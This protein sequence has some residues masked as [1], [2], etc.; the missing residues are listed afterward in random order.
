MP[1]RLEVVCALRG[2]IFIGFIV[3]TLAISCAAGFAADVPAVGSL[4]KARSVYA[5]TPLVLGASVSGNNASFQ[6]QLNG[7]D[8]AA[9]TNFLLFV[10]RAAATNAGAYSL[11]VSN[12]SGVV[13]GFVATVSVNPFPDHTR[14]VAWGRNTYSQTNIAFFGEAIACSAG[15]GHSVLLQKD[16]S[17]LVW[18]KSQETVVPTGLTNAVAIS[19]GS[20]HTLAL[21][22]NGTVVAW[23]ENA[24]G[25]CD[26]PA[27]LHDVVAVSANGGAS[28]A[29]KTDGTITMWGGKS[30]PF[31]QT[32]V[33]V[34]LN[35]VVGISAGQ[36][37]STAVRGDGTIVAW[38]YNNTGQI[39]VPANIGPAV[40]ICAGGFHTV[41]TLADGTVTAWGAPEFGVT[42]PPP[43]LSSPVYVGA[44][45]Y[46]TL[47]IS[48]DGQLIAWGLGTS[49]DTNAPSD[50][51]GQSTI[52]PNL[53]AA[54]AA[55]AG[56]HHNVALV[57]DPVVLTRDPQPQLAKPGST[58][59]LSAEASSL[60]CSFAWRLNG[61]ALPDQT[62]QT[63]TLPNFSVTAQGDYDVVVT[64][65]GRSQT[66]RVARV[67]LFSPTKTWVGLGDNKNWYDPQN[68]SP[69][70]RPAA[71]DEVEIPAGVAD[72]PEISS[73]AAPFVVKNLRCE[74]AFHSGQIEVSG[75]GLF[76]GSYRS[77]GGV[78]IQ[79]TGPNGWLYFSGDT[80][81]NDATLLATG[82]GWIQMPKPTAFISGAGSGGS[83]TATGAGSLIETIGLLE[84][85]GPQEGGRFLRLVAIDGGK[86]DMPSL[87]T[88]HSDHGG[89]YGAPSG[90]I[91]SASGAGTVINLPALREFLS[92]GESSGSA[93]SRAAGADIFVP[94]LQRAQAVSIDVADGRAFSLPSLT[95]YVSGP[96]STCSLS[97]RG[98]GSILDLPS[99]SK[100]AGPTFVYYYLDIAAFEGGVV[101]LPK[102]SQMECSYVN[103]PGGNGSDGGIRVRSNGADSS[104]NLPS[105]SGF[106]GD[107]GG[108]KIGSELHST[109]GGQIKVPNLTSATGLNLL[110]D[111]NSTLLL[112]AL[113]TYHSGSGGEGAFS[114]DGPGAIVSAPAL[115][116]LTGPSFAY[117]FFRISARH[118]GL[119]SAPA[120]ESL[121]CQYVNPPGGN[122]GEGGIVVTC[123]DAGSIIDFRSLL[124]FTGTG[125]TKIGSSFT[126]ASGGEIRAP[127]L[128]NATGLHL[129]CVDG[130]V[131]NMA[132][133][134]NAVAPASN[135]VVFD[136]SGAG[137]VLIVTNLQRFTGP[138]LLIQEKGGIVVTNPATLYQQVNLQLAPA[139]TRNP[140]E[141]SVL[142]GTP[143]EIKLETSGSPPIFQW[144]LN[145]QGIPGSTN[146]THAIAFASYPDAGSYFCI[147]SNTFGSI[148]SA[149]VRVTVA[150]PLT[151]DVRGRGSV[152]RNPVAGSD[153]VGEP[154]TLQAVPADSFHAFAGWADGSAQNPRSI[155]IGVSN[156][157]L[158]LFTNKIPLTNI[159][160]KSWEREIGGENFDWLDSV[161]ST[162]DGGFI[163]SGRSASAPGLN[164]FAPRRSPGTDIWVVK[165][166]SRGNIQWEK[167]FGGSSGQESYCTVL[168]LRNGGFLLAAT[169]E[170]SLPSATKAAPLRGGSDI[171]LIRLN[172]DGER[173]WDNSYGGSD[174]ETLGGN[175]AVIE[176]SDGGF[177]FTGYSMSPANTG[178]K[179]APRQADPGRDF[180][181]VKA[182]S[183]GEVEWDQTYW[184]GGTVGSG[185]FVAEKPDHYFIAGYTGKSGD[186][187]FLGWSARID[188]RDGARIGAPGIHGALF[189]MTDAA[190]LLDGGY[191]LGGWTYGDD[192]VNDLWL[193]RIDGAQQL[194]FERK[195]GGSNLDR[196]G[197]LAKLNE[198]GLLVAAQSSS[199]IGLDKTSP[200]YGGRDYWVL[201]VNDDGQITWDATFGGSADDYLSQA[202]QTADGGFLLGGNSKSG[203][204]APGNKTSA[205]LGDYDW[206]IVKLAN[207][208]IPVGAPIITVNGLFD[209]SSRYEFFSA[210][211]VEVAI[212]STLG[213]SNIFYTLNG[214][215][216]TPFSGLPYTNT[217]KARPPLTVR[218]IALN[219]GTTITNNPAVLAYVPSYALSVTN[220]GGAPVE[221]SYSQPTYPSN[222][223]VKLTAPTSD[224]GEW[225]FLRWDGAVSGTNPSV[226]VKMDSDKSVRGV[227][228][229]RLNIADNIEANPFQ[230]LYAYGTI[231][232][233]TPLP[234][235]GDRFD[236]WLING[237]P[238]GT[239]AP[240]NFQIIS[241]APQIKA[242]FIETDPNEA[243]L[244]IHIH[245][246]GGVQVDPP[247]PS[248]EIG[249]TIT[250]TPTPDDNWK[251]LGWSGARS[252]SDKPLVFQLSGPTD[253]TANFEPANTTTIVLAAPV[254]G[255]Y[256]IGAPVHLQ[257]DLSDPGHIVTTV[258][259]WSSANLLHAGGPTDLAFDWAL[260]RAGTNIIT[261]VARADT[262]DVAVSQAVQIFVNQ[263]PGV[264]L[265]SPT[266]AA[267]EVEPATIHFAASVSDPDF[268]PITRTEFYTND[269]LFVTT[270]NQFTYDWSNVPRGSYTVFAR[271]YD[272]HNG[273]SQSAS[274][275][276]TVNPSITSTA[277]FYFAT[278]QLITVE[279]DGSV[280]LHVFRK[281]G[282]ALSVINYATRDGSAVS[283]PSNPDYLSVGGSLDFSATNDLTV[284]VAL[285]DNSEPQAPRSF[286]L[287]LY[288]GLTKPPI[289]SAEI[290]VQDDPSPSHN[291]HYQR[292][293]SQ[294]LPDASIQLRLS[295]PEG[296]WRFPWLNQ[297]NP[298]EFVMK[299]L[300]PGAYDIEYKP[301]PGYI[302][303]NERVVSVT[304][305]M[306]LVHANSYSSFSVNTGRV[307]VRIEPQE[308]AD[309]ARW[310]FLDSEET[311]VSGQSVDVAI[312]RYIIEPLPIASW[313]APS[314]RPVNVSDTEERI[315]TFRYIVPD[316][317]ESPPTA[318]PLP[319]SSTYADLIASLNRE[320]IPYGWTG[321]LLSDLGSGSGTVVRE[322]VVITAAHVIWD[323][324]RDAVAANTR[325]LFQRFAGQ[326]EP[327][328]LRPSGVLLP[329]NYVSLRRA[330]LANHSDTAATAES[331]KYDIAILYFDSQVGRSGFSGFSVIDEGENPILSDGYKMLAG[332]AAGTATPGVVHATTPLPRA[333]S[334]IDTA[335][336]VF[337]TT[338]LRGLPGCSGGPL[339]VQ[340]PGGLYFPAAVY[341]GTSADA[342]YF[343][344]IDR[345]AERLIHLG[346]A[347]GASVASTNQVDPSILRIDLTPAAPSS[348]YANAIIRFDPPGITNNGA[349]F[350]ILLPNGKEVVHYQSS[351]AINITISS[352]YV[353]RYKVAPPYLGPA[354]YQLKADSDY[355]INLTAKY[356]MPFLS[357]SNNVLTYIAPGGYNSFF[358]VKDSLTNDK[359]TPLPPDSSSFN[360]RA[361]ATNGLPSE[362]FRAVINPINP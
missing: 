264:T 261:A 305:G 283:N 58:V 187:D 84:L 124:S 158:A 37:H 85:T 232:R 282:A 281:P 123:S 120:L 20:F 269:V 226:Y 334:Q 79:A 22:D 287:D 178:N 353:V 245:G 51:F 268:D 289:A 171:W 46:H 315:F 36:Y 310:R 18:G 338:S 333:F 134:T 2:L 237:I 295:P 17:V 75:G 222:Q 95:N 225:K 87:N 32:T 302:A 329:T 88:I 317:A 321:Q 200:N 190:A 192:V 151:L 150:Q 336:P 28:M 161:R 231:V 175:G 98:P 29:L 362:Y 39:N 350:S 127:R 142:L 137:S 71:S 361:R 331:R 271:A 318:L 89:I 25:Q 234:A 330:Y 239:T 40:S 347:F 144:Y 59:T 246:S 62:S 220:L 359:W 169:S 195:P 167:S 152:G 207:V 249:Q 196:L 147:V 179:K 351:V 218:A 324:Q 209:A 290:V 113:A 145:G 43:S 107:G 33:A 141:A 81:I 176:T 352:N 3:F 212:T 316:S 241:P 153:Y 76:S 248:Y 15:E 356:E 274:V 70:G 34:G 91:I 236:G 227:Y 197:S 291:R 136:A 322:R 250:V 69:P 180:W 243:R 23:G 219:G 57:A 1:L 132:A 54:V 270:T 242:E 341:L 259:F 346:S 14:V 73:S 148:T 13:T 198:G 164:K 208:E 94:N 38:G 56:M 160:V 247:G 133:L 319:A 188:K 149:P 5:G 157:Y 66:S 115:Q 60:S 44:G 128:A 186:N 304:S 258:S 16:G 165:F 275:Q 116:T 286:W 119:I 235:A 199:P 224:V 4:L 31:G 172:E 96:S 327:M 189:E 345:D 118:R 300:L 163:A 170:R 296:R 80:Q 26:V 177:L 263:P 162:G 306:R 326:F 292:L 217:F 323:E 138:A 105:L 50:N 357:F 201:R 7:T 335:S 117:F 294:V 233:L 112:P 211:E 301:L 24:Q 185:V 354:D 260:P 8:V 358:Q 360:L 257:A 273:V 314:P 312:G 337:Q 41:A 210:N 311:F 328:P 254:A 206:W 154:I 255:V 166:D 49:G 114:A 229:T 204:S 266:A 103:P 104:I 267:L 252:G 339:F 86:I 342:C 230:D 205:N 101:N 340:D 122:D 74:R 52:P 121:S 10:P 221:I 156:Y 108:A 183:A 140:Q 93:I 45:L 244:T 61:L 228:G 106:V 55:S 19:A 131:Q 320:H 146:A 42:T 213:A 203:V 251:F 110:A 68:W 63:L 174:N 191:W 130:G 53:G 173:L 276:V 97:A 277:D 343:R 309:Q 109:A 139:I 30:S 280:K 279:S 99:L 143:V 129:E 125:G 181:V 285:I 325:F 100:I 193:R 27:N 299:G 348:V 349:A 92:N 35:G 168:P 126:V 9:Q 253:L 214:K 67:T 6:W 265:L 78:T 293:P 77:D 216:P 288:D 307:T 355:D 284:A 72:A 313:Q 223:V 308:I 47:A 83:F 21:L 332:Y 202:A 262:G 278:N 297:W 12:S 182:N 238:T 90:V 135:P 64:S 215:T 272:N 159:I 298:S 102:V 256:Q 344:G 184:N 240:L 194:L 48:T 82:G 155:T 303:P 111:T 65:A 11:V